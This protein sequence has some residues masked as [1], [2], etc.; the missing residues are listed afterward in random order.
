[1]TKEDINYLYESL[2]FFHNVI[3]S[4]ERWSPQCDERYDKSRE[5]VDKLMLAAFFHATPEPRDE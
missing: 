5:I 4:S 1:M 2:S 3:N